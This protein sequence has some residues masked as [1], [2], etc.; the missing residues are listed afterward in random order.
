MYRGGWSNLSTLNYYTKK[1][2]MRDSIEKSD[3]LIDVD[4][5]ELEKLKE[6]NSDLLEKIHELG[7]GI[8][9]LATKRVKSDE[10][11]DALTKDPESLKLFARA[12]G[13]LG[14]INKLM[15]I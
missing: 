4:R 3:L 13:K 15:K 10:I 6:E 7:Q 11:L 5:T 14:L 2:G 9:K 1:I 12:L 8:K